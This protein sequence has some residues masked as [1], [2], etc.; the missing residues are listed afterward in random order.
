VGPHSCA[1]HVLHT[2][3]FMAVT[4]VPLNAIIAWLRYFGHFFKDRLTYKTNCLTPPPH[5]W[6]GQNVHTSTLVFSAG[7]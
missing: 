1:Y 6:F 3:N 5:I 2:A 4:F 7:I